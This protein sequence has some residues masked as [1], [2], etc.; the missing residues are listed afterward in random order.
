[1]LPLL[2]DH[3][4]LILLMLFSTNWTSIQCLLPRCV[5]C[6]CCIIQIYVL[7][8]CSSCVVVQEIFSSWTHKTDH[9]HRIHS[10]TGVPFSSMLFFDDENRNIQ[11]VTIHNTHFLASF[12]YLIWRADFTYLDV[13]IEKLEFD[14]LTQHGWKSMVSSHRV[15]CGST[16]SQQKSKHFRHFEFNV[17]PRWINRKSKHT[18][19]VCIWLQTQRFCHVSFN[20]N[21]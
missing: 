20:V 11:A 12:V 14:T 19:Y 13:S 16:L 9:F 7:N 1:M 17:D 3:Q 8:L 6:F 2:L 4:P 21:P 5:C 18:H 10:T 15:Q